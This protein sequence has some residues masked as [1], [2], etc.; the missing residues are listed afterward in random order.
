MREKKDS[1]KCQFQRKLLKRFQIQQIKRFFRSQNRLL[2][3][4][5]NLIQRS[6]TL[7][8]M[9]TNSRHTHKTN[10]VYGRRKKEQTANTERNQRAWPI[11][12][13]C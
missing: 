7:K 3:M 11:S 1:E 4:A 13:I 10:P 9:K 12:I 6:Y 2:I 5:L 8:A